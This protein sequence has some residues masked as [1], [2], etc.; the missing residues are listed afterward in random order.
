M[1]VCM[2]VCVC[3]Y[4]YI[5]I[6]THT[7]TT[8]YG[9]RTLRAEQL[10]TKDWLRTNGVNTNGAAAKVMNFDR[11]VK[12]VRPDTFGKIEVGSRGYPKSPSVEKHEICSDPISADPI[13]PSPKR[14]GRPPHAGRRKAG[15]SRTRR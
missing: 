12:K 11:L 6:Y 2:Y 9:A 15:R 13:C 3:I 1:Y 14:G 10:L 5:Y 7:N 8:T 4:I